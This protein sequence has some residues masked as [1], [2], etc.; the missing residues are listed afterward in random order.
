MREHRKNRK[1]SQVKTEAAFLSFFLDTVLYGKV[2]GGMGMEWSSDFLIG[3]LGQ[4]T[5]TL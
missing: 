2:K 5:S 3:E 4:A 1:D